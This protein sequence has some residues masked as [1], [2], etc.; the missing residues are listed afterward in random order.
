MLLLAL[1]LLENTYT[2]GLVPNSPDRT[3]EL[4]TQD[5]NLGCITMIMYQTSKT[6]MYIHILD[7]IPTPLGQVAVHHTDVAIHS[8][9]TRLNRAI[10]KFD[11]CTIR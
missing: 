6:Y 2:Q 3:F 11:V 1:L 5:F 7:H 4:E 8:K 10:S 9:S